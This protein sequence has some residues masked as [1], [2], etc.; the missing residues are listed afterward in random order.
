MKSQKNYK[1]E[2]S[3]PEVNSTQPVSDP[4]IDAI[5]EIIFGQNMKEYDQ[6]FDHVENKIDKNRAELDKQHD[7]TR[8]ELLDNIKELRE[9][10]ENRLSDLNLALSNEIDKLA[11]H[12][13][14]RNSL[15]SLL[16]AMASK[17][18]Y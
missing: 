3:A 15:A 8:E 13:V 11:E 7:E 17:L 1:E 2:E 9:E 16:E 12:K 18:R 6:Q 4:K 5:K 10:M 14:D